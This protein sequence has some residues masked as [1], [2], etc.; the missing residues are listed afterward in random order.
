MNTSVKI[1][2]QILSA[3]ML[4]SFFSC[5]QEE[6]RQSEITWDNWVFL[7]FMQRMKTS[8]WVATLPRSCRRHKKRE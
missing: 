4:I 1:G 3:E 6:K 5:S 8:F 2:I 7:T